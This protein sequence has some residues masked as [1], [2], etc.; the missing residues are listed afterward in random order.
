MSS[1]KLT[2]VLTC[3]VNFQEYI[4]D[5]IHNLTVHGNENIVVITEPEF[6][7]KFLGCTLIDVTALSDEFNFNEKSKLD[8]SFRGGFWHLASARFFVVYAY[9]KTFGVNRCL[10]IEN[11]VL[12][13]GK[14]A[15]IP[16][17]TTQMAGAYDSPTRMIPSVVWIPTPDSLRNILTNYDY[18]KN[19]MENF[20]TANI[21]RLPIFP[22]Y[23]TLGSRPYGPEFQTI[24]ERYSRYG[25]VFDAAAIGQFLG[26]VDPRNASGDTRG[27]VNET[28][29]VK[30]NHYE[31][32]WK[33]GCPFLKVAGRL[34]PIF[35][36][37]I[38]SKNLRVFKTVK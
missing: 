26:G 18:A 8:K 15:D 31:F 20:G 10:H 7:S 13:Y 19:D 30:Y 3:L 24:T 27:F 38:H 5:C 23:L 25:W 22:D 32:E 16:W 28:C 9:M 6:F 29:I 17:N 21:E 36:L 35:N 34:F 37:H 4:L 33:N 11:D 14:A 12:I 2:I 1:S